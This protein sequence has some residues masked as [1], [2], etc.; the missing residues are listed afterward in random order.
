MDT[1]LFWTIVLGG[2][3][4]AALALADASR[5]GQFT[6]ANVSVLIVPPALFIA[7][8]LVAGSQDA[9]LGLMLWPVAVFLVSAYG[10]ALKVFIVDRALRA[11]FLF[12]S[13]VWLVTASS[14]SVIF[15]FAAPPWMK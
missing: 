15:G 2:P 5:T 1:L 10:L 8:A 11:P 14:A 4:C 12:T 6:W 3:A 9:G 13:R 7:T